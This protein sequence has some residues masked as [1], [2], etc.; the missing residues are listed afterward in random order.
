LGGTG[1][2][3]LLE[4]TTALR[5]LLECAEAAASGEGCLAIIE[6]EPGIGKTRL[7]ERALE[8]LSTG[9]WLILRARGGE[10]E[11]EYAFGVVRQLFETEVMQ[12]GGIDAAGVLRGAAE[13][14]RPVLANEPVPAGGGGSGFASLHGLYWLVVNLAG[15]RPL[16]LAIDDAHWADGASLRWLA[17]CARRLEGL[18][19]LLLVTQRPTSTPAA[20]TELHRALE[21]AATLTVHPQPLSRAAVEQLT[22]SWL[23]DRGVADVA[24][25][26]HAMTG[27]NPFLVIELMRSLAPRTD[28]SAALV[29][30]AAPDKIARSARRRVERLGELAD[31]ALR[32][33]EAAAVFAHGVPLPHAADLAGLALERAASA[34]D[35]LVA[36]GVLARSV[37]V[38]FTHPVVR[39]S[40]YRSVPQARRS[41]MHARAAEILMN[42]GERTDEVAAHL[43][44]APPQRSAAVVDLLLRVASAA[45]G[46]GAPETAVPLLRRALA[47]QPA[48]SRSGEVLRLLGTAESLVQDPRS[49]GHLSAAIERERDPAARVAAARL[50][51]SELSIRIRIPEAMAVIERVA[52]TIPEA[53]RE[54]RLRLE[55]D[56][57]FGCVIGEDPTERLWALVTSPSG[58]ETPGE[59]LVLAAL[60][61]VSLFTAVG[62]GE[63]TATAR[64]A[65]G[66]DGLL[67]Y[68][69][70]E[71]STWVAVVASLML[72][73][74]LTEA[75]RLWDAGLEDARRRGSALGFAHVSAFRGMNAWRQG[76]LVTAAADGRAAL[77]VPGD[78]PTEIVSAALAP[79]LSGLTDQGRLEEAERALAE[80]AL[81]DVFPPGHHAGWMLEARGRLRLAQGNAE[82]ARLD[83][84]EAGRPYNPDYSHT[85]AVVPWR[86]GLACSLLALGRHEE[87]L[88]IADQEVRLARAFGAVSA[89]GIALRAR[90]LAAAGEER[91]SLLQA[92]AAELERTEAVLELARSQL[93]LGTALRIAGHPEDAR[94]PLRAALDAAYGCGAAP[95]VDRA[96]TE[97]KATGA[98]PR[99]MASSG[100]DALT[101]S[102]RRVA[103]LAASGLSNRE[104]AEALFLTQ[105]TVEIHL[106]GAYR[107]LGI[108][109]R[110]QLPDSLR[111]AAA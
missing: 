12:R 102:E 68:E 52:A 8:M 38:E 40:L 14:A 29:Q 43:L 15:E 18:P 42:A 87:A 27:G 46:R 6:G 45:L 67:P 5:S 99:R 72:C 108:S 17:Y 101:P 47:E 63:V 91:I 49:T 50:L 56:R 7:L 92:S 31:D 58:Q 55:S 51:I 77:D 53:E 30:R 61:V 104:I 106:G 94:A 16:V 57:W 1:T 89:I 62:A 4:R 19:I 79:L 75:R 54:L 82:Q 86:S 41:L 93:E 48:G 97:L 33:A 21:Q 24:A 73:G 69:P 13:L 95:M 20:N 96:V 111:G 36:A 35:A 84:E 81:P 64:R 25:A 3:P 100:V 110:G 85:P 83:F 2:A 60:A 28:V 37:P 10:L 23:G 71:S 107:K 109:G 88:E 70:S 78:L 65:L 80:R 44:R 74:H 59:R 90:A 105:R 32:L 76:D 9:S 22:S 66:R 103:E 39:S 34:A 11:S 98:R 26:C